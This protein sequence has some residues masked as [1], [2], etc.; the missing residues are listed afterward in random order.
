MDPRR[1]FLKR[2]FDVSKP[3]VKDTPANH[4]FLKLVS[5]GGKQ[6]FQG[7]FTSNHASFTDT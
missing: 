3:G 4:Y 1:R 2:S 6:G 5:R 7:P